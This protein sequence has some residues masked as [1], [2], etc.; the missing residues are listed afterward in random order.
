MLWKMAI[1]KS[2]CVPEFNFIKY[3]LFVE[4]YCGDMIIVFI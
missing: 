4:L 2:R 3:Q 1:N